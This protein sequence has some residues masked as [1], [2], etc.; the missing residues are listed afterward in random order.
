MM[1]VLF[2]QKKHEVINVYYPTHRTQSDPNLRWDFQRP[3]LRANEY[4]YCK[5]KLMIDWEAVGTSFRL[6]K[7]T[8]YF[9]S[10]HPDEESTE[11]ESSD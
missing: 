4:L 2:S 1:I 11:S 8:K 7:Y 3:Y 10:L 9:K 5:G 6:E